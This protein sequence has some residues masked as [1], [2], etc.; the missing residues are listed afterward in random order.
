MAIVD[1]IA[2]RDPARAGEAMRQ[3]LLMHQ[4]RLIRATSLGF[5]EEGV[6]KGD[7]AEAVSSMT[8]AS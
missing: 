3:H 7:A 2:D 8:E 6:G 1:A 4:E 5:L